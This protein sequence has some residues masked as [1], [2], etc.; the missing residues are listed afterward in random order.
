M[1]KNIESIVQEV[2]AALSAE[3]NKATPKQSESN[4][5]PAYNGAHLQVADYPLAEKRKDLI[6]TP[7]NKSLDEITLAAVLNGSVTAADVRITAETLELQAQ[8]A[9]SA[10]RKTFAANLRRAAEMTRIPDDRLL[11]IYNALRPNRS[12]KQDLLKIADELTHTYQA[13]INS[14]LVTEAAEVYELRN[15]LLK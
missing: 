1:S 7:T 2:L 9:E 5:K 10:G 11:E 14:K 13:P 8:I 15:V 6:K 4:A 3:G 12:T